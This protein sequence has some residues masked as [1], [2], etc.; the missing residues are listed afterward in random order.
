MGHNRSG[1]SGPALAQPPV[2]SGMAHR[3]DRVSLDAG[4]RQQSSPLIL[5]LLLGDKLFQLCQ[6]HMVFF[7]CQV[8]TQPS[9]S[10]GGGGCVCLG[11]CSARHRRSSSPPDLCALVTEASGPSLG[12][13]ID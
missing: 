4:V 7:I 10:R 1:D 8:R 9:P 12:S 3:Q 2:A 13:A 6:L 5:V 11:G